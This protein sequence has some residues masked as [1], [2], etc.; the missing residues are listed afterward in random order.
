MYVKKDNTNIT[1]VLSRKFLWKWDG[2]L[3]ITVVENE[4]LKSDVLSELQLLEEN[5]A[6]ALV[7]E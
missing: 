2:M 1:Q 4:S 6:N 5:A 3:I 7:T